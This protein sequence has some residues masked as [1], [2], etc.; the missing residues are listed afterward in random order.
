MAPKKKRKPFKAEWVKLPM[1]WAKAL[2][3][4]KRVSTYQ[5]AV[6][7][8]FEAFKRNH[9][10]GEIVLS[11]TMTGMSRETKRRAANELVELGLIKLKQDGKAALRVS[12][13]LS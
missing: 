6:A 4:S 9:V 5:L 1:R 3:R 13:I 8:L 10:G 11:S 7:I 2:R 12:S